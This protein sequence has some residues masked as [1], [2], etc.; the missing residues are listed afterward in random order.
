[1]KFKLS[2]TKTNEFSS[3]Q[4]FTEMSEIDVSINMELQ[5]YNLTIPAYEKFGSPILRAIFISRNVYTIRL[6]F[7]PCDLPKIY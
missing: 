2:I 1:M 3:H 7:Y 4:I 6:S 5:G